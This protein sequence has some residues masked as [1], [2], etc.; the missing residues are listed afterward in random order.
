MII[1]T[2]GSGFVG[3]NIL[4]RLNQLGEEDILIVDNLR[5][6][7]KYRNLIGTKFRDYLDKESLIALLDSGKVGPIRAVLHQGACTD[8]L[9]Y[10]GEYMIR[11]NFEFSKRLLHHALDNSAP[12]IYASSAA[13][14]GH[15]ELAVEDSGD[16]APLNIYGYSK[17]LLDMYVRRVIPTA[18][19]TI[20][21]LR[22]FNVYGPGETHKGKMS[23][24]VYQFYNQV[25]K[26]GAAKLFG[27]YGSFGP[28]MSTRDF[29]NVNDLVDINLFFLNGE[30]KKAVVNAGSGVSRTWNDLAN[31]VISSVG[32]GQIEYIDFP[33]SLA[34]K[35]Q[36]NTR[37]DLTKL[38]SLG[39][40]KEMTTLEAGV[41]AY[42][43]ALRAPIAKAAPSGVG[44]L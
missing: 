18:N 26:T 14:Y 41:D 33:L 4:K 36:F 19:S 37:A 10:D 28:G 39:F 34:D 30:T 2:G 24:M 15:T 13:V 40:T 35:Y 7:D 27:A 22:Y 43:S 25:T 23:S 21:G 12:Y 32:T 9:E 11:N 31:A 5:S 8:T 6:S 38:R 17:Y 1:L 16:E 44:T 29:V 42:V 3:S 20:V